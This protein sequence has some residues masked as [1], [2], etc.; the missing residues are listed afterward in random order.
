MGSDTKI[1]IMTVEQYKTE[2]VRLACRME[3]EHG[4]DVREVRIECDKVFYTDDGN[5]EDKSFKVSIIS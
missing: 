1:E 5:I 4:M 2:F 3:R